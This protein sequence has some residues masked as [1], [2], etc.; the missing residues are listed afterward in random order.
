MLNFDLFK[1]QTLIKPAIFSYSSVATLPGPLKYS[2][3]FVFLLPSSS[4]NHRTWKTFHRHL[5]MHPALCDNHAHHADPGQR[6]ALVVGRRFG[7]GDSQWRYGSNQ[8]FYSKFNK[9]HCPTP[10]YKLIGISQPR[11]ES[12]IL[13]SRRPSLPPV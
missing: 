9:E 5:K 12:S 13:S 6:H 1:K 10:T 3:G 8:R 11:A 2:A 7:Q 4:Y